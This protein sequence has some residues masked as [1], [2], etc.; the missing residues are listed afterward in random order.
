MGE[1]KEEV[2]VRKTRTKMTG[3]SLALVVSAVPVV[4]PDKDIERLF[5]WLYG[6]ATW[7]KDLSWTYRF[8]GHQ[9]RRGTVFLQSFWPFLLRLL[10]FTFSFF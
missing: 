10:F 5:A 8:R 4:S 9:H 7:K 6:S 1:R 2:E 3:F